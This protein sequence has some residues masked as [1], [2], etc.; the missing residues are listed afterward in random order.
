MRKV[1][2]SNESFPTLKTGE[3]I[4]KSWNFAHCGLQG[5]A[6]EPIKKSEI[7]KSCMDS[8]CEM[9]ESSIEKKKKRKK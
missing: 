8:L 2:L 5:I 1:F 3:R 4:K 9:F 7:W 6:K